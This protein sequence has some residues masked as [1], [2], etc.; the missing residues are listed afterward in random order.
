MS[1]E[2]DFAMVLA[3]L[4]EAFGEKH[5]TPVRIEAYHRGLKDIPLGLLQQTADRM[6]QTMGSESFRWTALPLVADIRTAAERLRRE[7]RAAHPWQPCCECEDHPRFREVTVEGVKRLERC[8][9]L[10]RHVEMLARLGAGPT[11]FVALPAAHEEP[12]AESGPELRSLPE[13]MQQRVRTIA[14]QKVLK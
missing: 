6:I 2:R 10:A 1:A 5:L 3:M 7:L 13:P 4:A 14:S 11:A 12:E 9:C 8:P